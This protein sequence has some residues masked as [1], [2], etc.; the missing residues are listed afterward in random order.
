MASNFFMQT[1]R[2]YIVYAKYQMAS[3]KA[4]V[5]VDFHVHELSEH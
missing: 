3:A 4:L 2:I 1:F 5:Q